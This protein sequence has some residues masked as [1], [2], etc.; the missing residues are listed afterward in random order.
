MLTIVAGL[1]RLSEC[2]RVTAGDSSMRA[3]SHADK[4]SNI[5]PK[6]LLAA[7]NKFKPIALLTTIPGLLNDVL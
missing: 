5:Q 2:S 6:A 4:H 3:Y 7:P 1:W